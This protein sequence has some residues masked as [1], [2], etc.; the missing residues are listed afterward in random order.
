MYVLSAIQMRE[1]DRATIR[2]EGA[3]AVSGATLMA[4]AAAAVAERIERDFPAALAGRIGILCGGGNNGGDGLVLARLLG[5]RQVRVLPLLFAPA[6]KLRGDAAAALAALERPPQEVLG[7]EA[8]AARR[9]EV[10]GCDLLVDALFGTGLVRPLQGWLGEVVA[11]LNREYRGPV[12][13]VDMPSGLGA[14]GEGPAEAPEAPVLRACATVTFTA[15]KRAHFLSRH[16]TA[17]GQLTVAPI[18]S[19]EALVGELAG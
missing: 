14:D 19:P 7:P 6:A 9:A 4:N 3:P 12:V 11:N 13:A 2:G 1:V 5:R 17:V 18:G 16:A 10:L 15:P 8:W